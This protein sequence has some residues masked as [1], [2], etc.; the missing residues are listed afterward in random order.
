MSDHQFLTSYAK[1]SALILKA[2]YYKNRWPEEG[3]R[4]AKEVLKINHTH[5]VALGIATES[6]LN[7]KRPGEALQYAL[8]NTQHNSNE[9]SHGLLYLAY[10][11]L[12]KFDKALEAAEKSASMA[13]SSRISREQLRRALLQKRVWKMLENASWKT[14]SLLTA[15]A[16]YYNAWK[17]MHAKKF[18]EA[19]D[20]II[21]A[22]ELS[23][24]NKHYE[25]LKKILDL[26]RKARLRK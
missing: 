6:L 20:A 4:L 19:L 16:L 22:C 15:E 8:K 14:T 5:A 1:L 2:D 13:P 18:D 25:L 12:G 26:K 21:E 10:S 3:L 7:L 11:H 9:V 23:S 24:V 17:F